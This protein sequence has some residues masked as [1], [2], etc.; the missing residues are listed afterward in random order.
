MIY[1]DNAATSLP[2]APGVAEEIL[3]ALKTC[4]NGSRSGHKPAICASEYMYKCREA[5][6]RMF[7]VQNPENVIFTQNA[8]HALN[9]A[10][11]GIL[12]RGDHAVISGY[13]HNAVLRPIYALNKKDAVE[14]TI[15]AAPLFDGDLLCEKMEKS[16]RKNTKCIICTHVSNVFGAIMPI[17]RIDS[18]C[19]KHGLIF[20]IDASQSAGAIPIDLRNFKSDV[21]LCMPGHKSLLGPQGTGVLIVAKDTELQTLIE[22]GTGSLSQDPNQPD[23]LPDRFES[24]TQNA[25]GIAG[26]LKAVE[27]VNGIGAD[28]IHEHEIKLARRMC[29]G[30]KQIPGT[31]VYFDPVFK[32]QSGVISAVFGASSEKVAGYLSDHD[33]CTRA[34]LHCSPLAHRTAGTEHTGTVRFSF[35]IFNTEKQV[36]TAI[37]IMMKMK[38]I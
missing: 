6:S 16:I 36:D 12:K 21:I 14:F 29:D 32:A 9:I 31:K 26:L 28:R 24:G 38:E 5:L 20:I 35:S 30:L 25:H 18:I 34:G 15:A 33:I 3:K 8:T 17:E 27:Y 4:G 10:V 19:A 22:G 1:F 2:K 7:H 23:F 37:D 13:E 11:K